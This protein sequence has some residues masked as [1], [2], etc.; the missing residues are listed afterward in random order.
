MNRTQNEIRALITLLGDDDQNVVEVARKE[1]AQQAQ[2]ALPILKEIGLSDSEGRIRI[3]AQALIEEIR[4]A[5][6]E[7]RFKS[8][9]VSPDFD[10]ERGCFI[11]AKIEYPKLQRARYVEI[12]DRHALEIQRQIHDLRN[13]RLIVDSINYYLFEE[14][15]FRGNLNAY[16]DAQNSFINRVLDQHLGI[17]ISLCAIYLFISQRLHLPIYGVS[18]PRHFLLKYR[19]EKDLFYIDVFNR[20]KILTREDCANIIYNQGMA[21][22]ESYLS[23]TPPMEIFARMLRNLILIYQ[24]NNQSHKIITLEK[25]FSDLI[26]Q[27]EDENL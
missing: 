3:Q 23:T 7:E 18:F 10:L 9:L 5:D 21:F 2:Q 25:I 22:Y 1:L 26:I 13:E 15:G 6:L 27:Q 19:K 8:L 14:I 4:L 20:G 24:H 17:P 11:L 12:L 16:Y